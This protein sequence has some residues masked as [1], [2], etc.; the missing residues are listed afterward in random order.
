MT[1]EIAGFPGL[2]V[3]AIGAE[4]FSGSRPGAHGGMV[5]ASVRRMPRPTGLPCGHR[6]DAAV[7]LRLPHWSNPSW[8]ALAFPGA[9]NPVC[10]PPEA[11]RRTRVTNSDYLSSDV[12]VRRAP[13]RRRRM[14]ENAART[15]SSLRRSASTATTS[16]S[17]PRGPA[18]SSC[19]RQRPGRLGVGRFSILAGSTLGGGTVV[20]NYIETSSLPSRSWP[21][22]RTIR[23]SRFP[24]FRRKVHMDL[25]IEHISANAEATRFDQYP[26]SCSVPG[27]AR[28][29][30]RPIWPEA[31]RSTTTSSAATCARCSSRLQ[32]F[33][34]EDLKLQDA[35]ELRARAVVNC[36]ADRILMQGHRRR[37]RASSRAPTARPR[38]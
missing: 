25:V 19:L 13:Q 24:P 28:L 36:R 4:G 27:W 33:R 32:S 8:E 5:H 3:D 1:L 31:P 26:A 23:L 37:R 17:Q 21:S 16:T 20:S 29:R 6:P 2:P 30:R 35:S 18:T 22:R 14:R 9:S 7:L 12:G 10:R 11:V 34:L 15:C 38:R